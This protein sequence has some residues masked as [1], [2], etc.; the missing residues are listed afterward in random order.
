M[1]HVLE[2]E[3]ILN[4]N[5]TILPN[6]SKRLYNEIYED[7]LNMFL[8]LIYVMSQLTPGFG[9]HLGLGVRSTVSLCSAVG[10]DIYHQQQSFSLDI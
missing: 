1:L 7:G 8:I 5:R 4:P 10:G 3:K 2:I 6:L 9:A